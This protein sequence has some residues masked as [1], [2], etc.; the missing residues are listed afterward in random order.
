M[1]DAPGPS[2]GQGRMRN[3]TTVE[4]AMDEEAVAVT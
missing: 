1:K 4:E 2:P 3:Y